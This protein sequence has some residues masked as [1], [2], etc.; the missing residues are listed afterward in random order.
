MGGYY[1]NKGLFARRF[2]IWAQAIV[3]CAL[4]LQCSQSDN[5]I[6]A[7]DAQVRVNAAYFAKIEQCNQ[8]AGLLLLV[9]N[10]VQEPDVRLC[11]GEI[12]AAACPIASIPPSC[13]LLFFKSAPNPDVD[14]KPKL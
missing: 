7:W 4:Y 12:L 1:R 11:E 2:S 6:R 9:P 13:F 8:P 10:D 14:K 5:V 3:F